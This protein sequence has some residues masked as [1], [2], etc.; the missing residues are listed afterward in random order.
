MYLLVNK[1]VKLQL[2]G[3]GKAVLFIMITQRQPKA[4]R[5]QGQT[6]YLVRERL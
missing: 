2:G 5:K 4:R 1:N 3:Q 6:V